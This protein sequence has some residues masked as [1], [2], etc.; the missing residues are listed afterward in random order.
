M[1][2]TLMGIIAVAVIV[3]A[4]MKNHGIS[5]SD[6]MRKLGSKGKIKVGSARY[7]V[8]SPEDDEDEVVFNRGY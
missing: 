8:L 7:V 4:V 5:I 2:F 1:V 6:V 3:M